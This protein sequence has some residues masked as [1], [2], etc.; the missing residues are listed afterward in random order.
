MSWTIAQ[1]V[2]DAL[3][4]A[5]SRRARA[6]ALPR[7]AL[8]AAIVARSRRYTSERES[9]H[10]PLAS[11]ERDADL[12]A[13]A[14]FF[15]VADAAKIMIPLAELDRDG[16]LPRTGPLSIL[17]VGAG[18]GAM[19]LGALD[20]LRRVDAL[21]GR[22][23]TVRALDRDSTALAI[24]ADAVAALA[25]RWSAAVTVERDSR[26]VGGPGTDDEAGLLGRPGASRADLVLLG[27]LLNELDAG[28][29]P[30]LV[31]AA[32]DA[33]GPD[34][35][36]IAIEPALRQTTRDLHQLR[37]WVIENHLARVVAPCVRRSAPCPALEDERDWC[38]EDRTTVL[39]ARAG[40][41]A[42][43]TGLRSH[44]LKFSYLVLRRSPGSE[45]SLAV[46]RQGAG[47]TSDREVVRV[48]SQLR[49]SK[50]KIECFGCGESGRVSLRLLRRNRSGE[51]RPFERL[52]RGDLAVIPRSLASGGD[53]TRDDAIRSRSVD[54][55]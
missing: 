47:A 34:G 28:E 6:A 44:G 7:G 29:R 39:P 37:D 55:P 50:G 21:T 8:S 19:T 10:R 16:L 11:A 9:L 24:F 31:R 13:R 25:A 4:D 54:P 5:A 32:L 38:H 14:V 49:K 41:L 12:A 53:I 35:S 36:M 52:E 42:R 46:N 48:V 51:N 43:A 45:S 1:D 26:I 17:D 30:G 2:E 27:G 3:W 40:K 22:R 33:A 15:G 20:Y 18:T 23:I